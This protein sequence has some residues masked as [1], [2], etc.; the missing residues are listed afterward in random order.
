MGSGRSKLTCIW[1]MVALSALSIDA[2]RHDDSVSEMFVGGNSDS[3]GEFYHT[4]DEIIT[5]IRQLSKSCPYL[6]ITP[7]TY[8]DTTLQAITVS[9]HPKNASEKKSS[10]NILTGLLIFGEHAR[11]LISPELALSFVKRLCSNDSKAN[12]VLNS[13]RFRI[14]PVCNPEGRRKVEAGDYCRRTN[15]NGVDLN[16]NWGDH[17]KPT[18][19]DSQ[20][21]SWSGPGK[22]SEGETLILKREVTRS[23]PDLFITVHSGILGMYTPYAWSGKLP[24]GNSDDHEQVM[25]EIPDSEVPSGLPDHVYK[26]LQILRRNDEKYCRCS[27]GPAGREVGYLCSGT[28]LD[29]IYDVAKTKY[30]FGLEIFDKNADLGYANYP[31]KML[32]SINSTINR[33]RHT[34]HSHSHGHQHGS[35]CF[36]ESS[37]ST[38]SVDN[39]NKKARKHLRNHRDIHK[40]QYNMEKSRFPMGVESAGRACLEAFNP[41]TKKLYD[42]TLDNWTNALLDIAT[43]VVRA[44]LTTDS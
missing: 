37:Q 38:T 29:Y 39:L 42:E 25:L 27:A 14:Y 19:K 15:S 24:N 5:E 4:T 17:W 28:C 36:I 3:I 7:E 41:V 13:F 43:D 8:Q 40:N 6:E 33:R 12:G 18:P 21:Q 22:F 32:L 10:E 26:M 1:M 23:P 34:H 20:S 9:K 11:E 30:T 35:S 16:R 31:G 44:E 2:M